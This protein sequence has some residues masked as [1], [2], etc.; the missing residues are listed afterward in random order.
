MDPVLGTT[1][2]TLRPPPDAS[3]RTSPSGGLV[4]G[5]SSPGRGGALTVVA[6]GPRPT[7]GGSGARADLR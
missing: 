1:V 6:T 2:P 4:I 5:R 7:A 3:A